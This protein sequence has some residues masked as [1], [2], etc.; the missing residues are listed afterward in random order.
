MGKVTIWFL[1]VSS[2]LLGSSVS[3]IFSKI[4]SLII[5]IDLFSE[6]IPGVSS[7]LVGE[8][9]FDLV[10]FLLSIFFSVSFFGG[11]YLLLKIIQKKDKGN[12]SLLFVLLLVILSIFIFLQTHFVTYSGR[13]IMSLLVLFE[14]VFFAVAFSVRQSFKELIQDVKLIPPNTKYLLLVNG[15]FIG[16]YLLLILNQLTTIALLSL[17]VMLLMPFVFLWLEVSH[18]SSFIKQ[19]IKKVPGVMVIFAVFFPTNLNNIIILGLLMICVWF[20]LQFRTKRNILDNNLLI[21]YF[22][23]IAIIFLIIYNPSFYVGNFDTVEEGFFLGWVQR[24]INGQVLYRDAS[25]YHPPF[26]TWAMYYFMRLTSFTLY[27]ERLFLH[28]LQIVGGVIYFFFLRKVV[29]KTWVVVLVFGLFLSLVGTE[30]RNNVEFRVASGMVGILTLFVYFEKQKPVYL[31]GAGVF[32]ALAVFVSYETGLSSLATVFIA[33]NFLLPHPRFYSREKIKLNMVLMGGVLMGLLPIL[34]LLYFQGALNGLWSQSVFYASSFSKGYFNVPLDRALSLSYFH[35]HIFY[36]YLSSNA[37]WW[38]A[39]RMILTGGFL[40]FGYKLVKREELDLQSRYVGTAVLFGIILFRASLGR[41]DWYHL[42]FLVP[43]AL[44]IF[45]FTLAKLSYFSKFSAILISFFMLF[46]IAGDRVNSAFL[47]SQIFKFQTYGRVVGDYK[48]FAFPRGAGVRLGESANVEDV[49]NLVKFLQERVSIQET[50][51]SFPWMPEIYF[52]T[53]RGNATSY[54]VPYA[55]YSEEYQVE[56]ISEMEI[57]SSKFVVFVEGMNFGGLTAESL[58][59]VN[60]FILENYEEVESFGR[61]KI[62]VKKSGSL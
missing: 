47:Q 43:A 6:S 58:P 28:M 32:S 30:V 38:E 9:T 42:L 24:L 56:M 44:A 33:L 60:S 48:E 53:D 22:Y 46:V 27:S 59:L 4:L 3:L 20:I 7:D 1:I 19:M 18:T 51:F 23:P 52:Y 25:L 21:K 41:S 50:I 34:I 57:D 39:V 8:K 26:I 2:I 36:Q 12:S 35:F 40:Y 62:M 49:D 45:G 55:F 13:Q 15:L 16:F 29:G 14:I 11:N 31:F 5:P 10:D 37:F 54:D 17:F 61:Y